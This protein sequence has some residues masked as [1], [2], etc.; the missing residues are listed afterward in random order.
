MDGTHDDFERNL[1][2]SPRGQRYSPVIH[3]I[4][5]DEELDV[6][7]VVYPQENQQRH[8]GGSDRH[9]HEVGGEGGPV[10]DFGGRQF[11]LRYH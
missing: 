3:A 7:P 10:V 9:L 8:R 5:N 1:Y 11:R 2:N 6:Q 4:V